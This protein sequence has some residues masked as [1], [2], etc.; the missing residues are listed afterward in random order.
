MTLFTSLSLLA[1]VGFVVSFAMIRFVNSST[2]GKRLASPTA[3]A[4]STDRMR[5]PSVSCSFVLMRIVS[6]A[7]T[8][9][10]SSTVFTPV[11]LAISCTVSNVT[12]RSSCF[13]S[14][15]STCSNR[16]V[17]STSKSGDCERSVTSRSVNPLRSHSSCALPVLFSK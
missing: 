10:P 2:T 12:V 3:S 17:P 9:L 4:R 11:R 6:P 8:K 16:S 1:S 5:P 13:L 7:F 15:V 14:D